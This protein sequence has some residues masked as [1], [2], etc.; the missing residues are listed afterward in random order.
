M[1]AV[2][3]SVS[4]LMIIF[5]IVFAGTATKSNAINYLDN[6]NWPS[7]RV[8]KNS[9]FQFWGGVG[10]VGAGLVFLACTLHELNETN[11]EVDSATPSE[12]ETQPTPE[13][14]A[15]YEVSNVIPFP[16]PEEPPVGQPLNEDEFDSLLNAKL[17]QKVGNQNV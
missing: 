14:A 3:I 5:G 12:A 10:V 13:V 15:S 6:T 2:K 8:S 1:T 11:K 9:G 7:E 17:N 4:I 16:R